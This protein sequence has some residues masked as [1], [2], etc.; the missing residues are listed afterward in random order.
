MAPESELSLFPTEFAGAVSHR[1]TL[2]CCLHFRVYSHCFGAVSTVRME[3]S[4]TLSRV[5]LSAEEKPSSVDEKLWTDD[6]GTVESFFFC[7]RRWIIILTRGF[8]NSAFIS[9]LCLI[10]FVFASDPFSETEVVHIALTFCCFFLDYK[11]EAPS[12]AQ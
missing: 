2:C 11:L 9:Y 1:Y 8:F 7:K 6:I 4:I 5:G 10:N 3:V 12:L